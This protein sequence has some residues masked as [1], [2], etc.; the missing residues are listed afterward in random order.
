HRNSGDPANPRGRDYDEEWSK[1]ASHNLC[2]GC[3]IASKKGPVKCADCHQAGGQ[4]ARGRFRFG[5]SPA[6][7]GVIPARLAASWIGAPSGRGGQFASPAWTE[8]SQ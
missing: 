1:T 7:V 4:E 2:I 3:H 5:T 6:I 8:R